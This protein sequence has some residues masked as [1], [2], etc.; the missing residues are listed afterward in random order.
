MRTFFCPHCGFTLDE[1]ALRAL[2]CHGCGATLPE[3]LFWQR[4]TAERPQGSEQV[5]DLDRFPEHPGSPLLPAS[6]VPD[7]QIRRTAHGETLAVLALLVPLIAQGLLLAY[8]FNSSRV[9]MA[10][11][12][13]TIAVTAF[14]LAVDAAFLGTTDLDGDERCGPVALFFGMLLLWIVCYPVAFFRRRHFGRP[15]LGPLAI[16]V[17]GFFVAVP[18]VREFKTFGIGGN[19]VPTCTSPEV[20]GLVADLIRKTTIGPSVQSITGHREISFDPV[21]KVRKGQCQV[22]TETETITVTYNVTVINRGSGTFQVEIEG[23]LSAEP[24][25]CTDP[26]VTAMVE[27]MIRQSPKGQATQSV[28]QFQETQYDAA[29]RTRTGQCQVKTEAGA[30][31]VTYQVKSV[32]QKW[33]DVTIVGGLDQPPAVMQLEPGQP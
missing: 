27:D 23:F 31:T 19:G 11:L 12:W 6:T 24:P 20:T 5:T 26:E 2:R 15:N 10:L 16:L 7:I 9:E 18:F 32:K 3:E 8:Q 14:V 30:F 29:S 1:T 17:A 13:G 21:A 22:K 25:S 28:D 4:A 33:F